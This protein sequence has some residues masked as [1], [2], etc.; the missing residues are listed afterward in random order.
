MVQEFG[1]TSQRDSLANEIDD[2]FDELDELE[3]KDELEV[4]E[5]MVYL[6]SGGDVLKARGIRENVTR[7]EAIKWLQT[8]ERNH[9]VRE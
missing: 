9:A 4:L 5:D 3:D 6:L 8:M 2:F 7:R 1:E